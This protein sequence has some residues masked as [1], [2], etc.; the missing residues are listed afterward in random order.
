MI[1]SF[2]DRNHRVA[3]QLGDGAKIGYGA[4]FKG[5]LCTT[6]KKYI[7][8]LVN[9]GFIFNHVGFA[10]L[11]PE[12]DY[13]FSNSKNNRNQQTVQGWY[14]INQFETDLL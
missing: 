13:W 3:L 9:E 8:L 12:I 10:W 1:Q 11:I 5:I 14:S 6:S 4:S 2:S 7:F